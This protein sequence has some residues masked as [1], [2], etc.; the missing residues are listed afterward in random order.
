MK[1]KEIDAVDI[2]ILNILQT[3]ANITNKTLA[4]MIG[5]T[6][7]PTLTRVQNLI[8]RGSIKS[9]AA[10]ISLGYF[11]YRRRAAFNITVLNEHKER[12]ESLISEIKNVTFCMETTPQNTNTARKY[13]L[14]FI[15]KTAEQCTQF[16]SVILKEVPGIISIETHIGTKLIKEAKFL[17]DEEKDLVY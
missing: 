14:I 12:F 10:E 3:E 17:L 2:K 15:G 1:K 4:K 8:S 16:E 5:L 9:Y 7:G 6:P 11:G 13:F